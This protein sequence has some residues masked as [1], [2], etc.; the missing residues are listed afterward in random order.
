[1]EDQDRQ[2]ESQ[3]NA[4]QELPNGTHADGQPTSADDTRVGQV[5]QGL[6]K[7]TR[8][9]PA[10][11]TATSRRTDARAVQQATRER[12]AALILALGDPNNTL[13]QHAVDRLLPFDHGGQLVVRDRHDPREAR[14]ELPGTSNRGVRDKRRPA[15][16]TQPDVLA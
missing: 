8:Q 16:D 6:A 10:V 11:P 4:A 12:I 1:M 9:L 3:P 13:H 15:G 14:S 5:L 2:G 7:V